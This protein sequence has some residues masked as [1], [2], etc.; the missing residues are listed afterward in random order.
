MS[1]CFQ[2]SLHRFS[3]EGASF[4]G[5]TGWRGDSRLSGALHTWSV[6]QYEYSFRKV[7]PCQTCTWELTGNCY[8]VQSNPLA[9]HFRGDKLRQVTHDCLLTFVS[10]KS[11]YF[12]FAA[13]THGRV[14]F[15]KL[16]TIKQLPPPSYHF[17]EWV[18]FLLTNAEFAACTGKWSS[19]P[20]F[21]G[22]SCSLTLLSVVREQG[23]VVVTGS[24]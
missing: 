22:C 11:R 2:V 19:E 14:N 20:G 7:K 8:L 24:Q 6:L 23:Q 21:L 10:E 1:L 12:K 16:A 13:H 15:W 4:H 9:S 18:P 17:A 3:L 5:R